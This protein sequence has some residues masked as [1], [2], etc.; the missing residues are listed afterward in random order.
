MAKNRISKDTIK[1][2][3]EYANRLS[4]K[5]KLHIKKVIVFGSQV[6][7]SVGKWSDIDVCIISPKFK[8]MR[9]ALEFLWA[10][11]EKEEVLK[12]LEP[13]GFSEED[14]EKGSDLIEEIKKNGVEIK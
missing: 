2:V 9:Q 8:N 5:E 4:I 12:G 6:K 11:R 3:K 13:I 14:F 7:G 10:K 1:V